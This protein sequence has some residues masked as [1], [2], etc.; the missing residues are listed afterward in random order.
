MAGRRCQG[1]PP[2]QPALGEVEEERPCVRTDNRYAVLDEDTDVE[3]P[4]EITPQP[5]PQRTG[6]RHQRLTSMAPLRSIS[7]GSGVRQRPTT[8]PPSVHP[9]ARLSEEDSA[10]TPTKITPHPL[11]ERTGSAP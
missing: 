9:E 4:V 7:S 3:D 1:Y 10:M 5:L 6:L 2:S 8:G 11:S